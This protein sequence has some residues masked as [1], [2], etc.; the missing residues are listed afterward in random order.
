[1]KYK[2]QMIDYMLILAGLNF[3]LDI[4]LYLEN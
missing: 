1:M 4:Y 2:L 3:A